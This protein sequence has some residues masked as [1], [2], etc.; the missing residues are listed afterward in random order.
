MTRK[1]ISTAVSNTAAVLDLEPDDDLVETVTTTKT[2][3]RRKAKIEA[4]PDPEPEFIADDDPGDFIDIDAD[5]GDASPRYSETSLAALVYGD[6]Q[7][8]IDNRYCTVTIR[9]ER[10]SLDDHFLQPC[11]S[12]MV[13]SPLRN[14]PLT[15]ER[16]DIEERVRIEHGGGHYLFQLQFN[17]RLGPSWK[18]T[19]ADDPAAVRAAK[20]QDAPAARPDPPAAD[21]VSSFLDNL[22]KQRRMKDLLFGDREKEFQ[23]QIA[24]MKAEIAAARSQPTEPKSERLVLLE[25]ALAAGQSTD[26]QSR[27]LDNLFP[28]DEPERRHW[29]ADVI[30]VAIQ[31][32]EVLAG[33]IAGVFGG[34]GGPMQPPPPPVPAAASLPVSPPTTGLFRRAE[35]PTEAETVEAETAETENIIETE[36]A[37]DAAA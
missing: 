31:N 23:D 5:T 1:K 9:R 19:L 7:D 25:T 34:L 11:N 32:R 16:I 13:L 22:E 4:D 2:I 20:T 8:E 27:I 17:G 6:E 29:I 3:G 15:D 35:P 10:D 33:L 26:L 18:A 12:R 24:E 28:S 14:I 21:P 37:A 30:D 36:I